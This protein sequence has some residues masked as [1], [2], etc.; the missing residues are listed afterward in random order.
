MGISI[1]TSKGSGKQR[2]STV[3]IEGT[4][5]IYDVLASKKTLV[6]ALNSVT[7]LEIDLSQVTEIDTAGMQLLVLLKRE[8]LMA[9]KHVRLAAHSQAS[10]EVL[11]RYNLGGYFGDPVVISSREPT[12]G[13]RSS[14]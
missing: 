11:D 12:R 13:N 10:V 1:T 14:H 7:E 2:R 9:G 3:V 5:T 8:A 4:L 6:E